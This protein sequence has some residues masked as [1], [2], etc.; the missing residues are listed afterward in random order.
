MS[1]FLKH[2]NDNPLEEFKNT[3]GSLQKKALIRE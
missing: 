1:N 3:I 2:V